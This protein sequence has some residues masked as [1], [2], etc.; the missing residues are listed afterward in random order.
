MVLRTL[1]DLPKII[2]GK[3]ANILVRHLLGRQRHHAASLLQH[4]L[5]HQRAGKAHVAEVG[6]RHGLA[7]DLLHPMRTAVSQQ[8]LVC[9]CSESETD[10]PFSHFE[11]VCLTT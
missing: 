6:L 10:I 5:L 4:G 8:A 9:F 11:M 1:R 2:S 7:E 3:V